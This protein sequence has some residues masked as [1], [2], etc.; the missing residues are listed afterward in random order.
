MAEKWLRKNAINR[1]MRQELVLNYAAMMERGEWM[2]NGESIIIADTGMLLDGQHRLSAIILYGKPVVTYVAMGLPEE[3]FL[4]INQG[5]SRNRSDALGI[6]GESHPTRLSSALSLL[7]LY[8]TGKLKEGVTQR[9]AGTNLPSPKQQADLLEQWPEMREAILEAR[10]VQSGIGGNLNPSACA[11]GIVVLGRI[12]EEDA[13]KFFYHLKTGENISKGS[14]IGVLRQMLINYKVRK[15]PSRSEYHLGLIFTAW[16]KWRLNE[17]CLAL[18]YRHG[19][20]E[21]PDPS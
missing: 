21:F 17:T 8:V 20:N 9:Y 18:R 6:C 11:V 3:V 12:D 14:P 4:T 5:K 2:P 10:R 13:S 1:P 7:H 15:V 19:E 16:K